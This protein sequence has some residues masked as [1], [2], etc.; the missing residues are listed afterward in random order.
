[1]WVKLTPTQK[2]YQ[3][4]YSLSKTHLCA[5]ILHAYSWL[6]IKSIH[7]ISRRN[8]LINQYFEHFEY[9][10]WVKLTPTQKLYQ[11]LYSLSKTHLCAKILHIYSWL[12]I[13]SIHQISRINKLFNQYFEHFEYWVWVK[14]TPTQKLYQILYSLSKTH[15]CV[16]IL[17]AYSWLQI[18][19]IHQISRRNKLFNQYFEHFEYWV[20]VK[21]TP[22]QK[23]Y[24]IV[25]SL[26]KTHLC[27]KTLHEHSWL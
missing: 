5:K 20:W 25:Y 13:K 19:S 15:L 22:T 27:V 21:L 3:I 23:L 2:L 17:H 4:V 16:K 1:M 11:T 18:K 6:Y 14:L 10:V 9:W 8:K 7:Q 26:S 24:Q 12:Q